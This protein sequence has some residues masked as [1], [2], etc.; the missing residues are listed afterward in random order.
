MN[1]VAPHLFSGIIYA[2]DAHLVWEDLRERFDKVKKVRIFQLHRE[3]AT[4]SQGTDSVSMYFTKLKELWAEYDAMIPSLNCGCPKS[5]ENVE[6]FLQQRLL[7]FLG[8]LNDSYDQARRQILMKTTEPTLNQAYAM[9]TESESQLTPTSGV[10]SIVEGNDITT[11]WSAKGGQ[12]KQKRNFNLFCEHCK[13]K[14]HTRENC[15]H[16]IGYPPNYKGRK[17][18]G[19]SANNV[20][21]FGKQLDQNT[22][23]IP[24]QYYPGNYGPGVYNQGYNTNKHGWFS[25]GE[26]RD[27]NLTNGVNQVFEQGQGI[28]DNVVAGQGATSMNA[29]PAPMIFTQ[30]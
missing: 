29:I 16:L 2:S 7:Q 18:N 22:N 8:G 5:K 13:L 11:L 1:T 9:I 24:G 27:S 26:H 28:M 14:G 20:M 30:E 19:P 4:I 6:H 17:K 23:V 21:S 25:G 3:I 12:Q 15:Y 10:N